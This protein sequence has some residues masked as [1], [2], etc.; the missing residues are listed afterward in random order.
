MNERYKRCQTPP[1]K[2]RVD[3][4]CIVEG[5]WGLRVTYT[6]QDCKASQRDIHT[7]T[8]L[9]ADRQGRPIACARRAH[10]TQSHGSRRRRCSRRHGRRRRQAR[11]KCSCYSNSPSLTATCRVS[12]A[13]TP[14]RRV[15]IARAWSHLCVSV[16]IL[17][18]AKNELALQ[19]ATSDS[20]FTSPTLK[21][22]IPAFGHALKAFRQ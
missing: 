20:L 21:K 9:C 2:N 14:S 19:F 17:Y 12:P 13:T 11:P 3:C 6:C 4:C 22:E 7:D 15:A 5:G 1:F 18:R 16:Q 8:R 10:V